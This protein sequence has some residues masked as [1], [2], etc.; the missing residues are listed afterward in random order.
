[1]TW[2]HRKCCV[3]RRDEDFG[4]QGTITHPLQGH[5]RLMMNNTLNEQIEERDI[6]QECEHS[7]RYTQ[8]GEKD[9]IKTIRPIEGTEGNTSQVASYTQI[10]FGLLCLPPNQS[11]RVQNL[12]ALHK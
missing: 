3:Q 9:L 10:L 2:E 12:A 11:I 5:Y 4:T 6:Q 1:M 8:A 7:L